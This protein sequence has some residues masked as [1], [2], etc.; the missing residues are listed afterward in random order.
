MREDVF[1][2]QQSRGLVRVV[3]DL[4]QRDQLVGERVRL[5]LALLEVE[6]VV[7]VGPRGQR[8]VVRQ[9]VEVRRHRVDGRE[10]RVSG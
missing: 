7:E 6:G 3:P 9:P 1:G 10:R 8:A 2:G 4:V 5:L